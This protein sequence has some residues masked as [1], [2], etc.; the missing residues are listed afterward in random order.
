MYEYLLHVG[1]Q[2]SAQTFLNEVN[3]ITTWFVFTECA[4]WFLRDAVTNVQRL[5]NVIRFTSIEECFRSLL[6]KMGKEY[7]ARRASWFSSFMVVVS[8]AND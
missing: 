2:K 3:L 5:S 8:F 7:N 6:D 1:A 4:S